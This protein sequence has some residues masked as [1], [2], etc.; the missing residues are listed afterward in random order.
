VLCLGAC[1]S[2]TYRVRYDP[3]LAEV[4]AAEQPGGE[5]VARL[6]VSVRG[7]W[8]EGLQP[9]GEFALHLRVR[10]E[11]SGDAPLRFDPAAAQLLNAD[12]SPFGGP[13]YEALPDGAAVAEIA[14]GAA[15]MLELRFL[16][17]YGLPP[18]EAGLDGLSFRATLDRLGKPIELSVTF[19]RI[20]LHAY[21]PWGRPGYSPWYDGY[22]YP[23]G[24]GYYGWYHAHACY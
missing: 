6:L 16:F 11:N 10:I 5:P 8:R 12:L 19:T 2:T 21:D 3:T 13:L 22:W 18:Q 7:A 23:G 17:P 4:L 15:L 24:Y 1:T 9:E 20:P 14:P